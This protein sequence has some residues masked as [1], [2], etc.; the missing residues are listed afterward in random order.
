MMAPETPQAPEETLPPLLTEVL[1][2]SDES[3]I[4]FVDFIRHN[5]PTYTRDPDTIRRVFTAYAMDDLTH[6]SREHDD[7]SKDTAIAS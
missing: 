5:N 3:L 4:A 1:T 2:L 7:D 6:T